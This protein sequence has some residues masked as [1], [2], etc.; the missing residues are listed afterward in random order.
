[1]QEYW[2]GNS[3]P[4]GEDLQKGMEQNSSQLSYNS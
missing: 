3:S 1:M 2:E 4:L